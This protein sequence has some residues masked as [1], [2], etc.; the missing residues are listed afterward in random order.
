M[1]VVQG[2]KVGFHMMGIVFCLNGPSKADAKFALPTRG[3]MGAF[4]TDGQ[5]SRREGPRIDHFIY[6]K[7]LE[8]AAEYIDPVP[9]TW[10]AVVGDRACAFRESRAWY[11]AIDLAMKHELSNLSQDG[12][13]EPAV[14]FIPG[15]GVQ[16]EGAELAVSDLPDDVR[17]YAANRPKQSDVEGAI[18]PLIS[19]PPTSPT[20]PPPSITSTDRQNFSTAKVPE[21][22]INRPFGLGGTTFY[23]R[24]G[25]FDIDISSP[26]SNDQSMDDDNGGEA[27]G[28]DAYLSRHT[29]LADKAARLMGYLSPSEEGP[30]TS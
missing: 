24:Q 11:S 15:T 6:T 21:D 4:V 5:W 27:G 17:A 19:R 18:A 9:S 16:A 8:F 14:T 1:D 25:F 22:S 26:D 23:D 12:G 7:F 2:D 3:C 30:S 20:R 29:E 10:L 28:T 13:W